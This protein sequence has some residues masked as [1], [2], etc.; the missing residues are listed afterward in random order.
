MYSRQGSSF[1]KTNNTD[2]TF[3]C[4]GQKERKQMFNNSHEEK[5]RAIY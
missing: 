3:S 2:T 5:I 4:P 1:L